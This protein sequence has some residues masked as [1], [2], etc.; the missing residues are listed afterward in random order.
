VLFI[1]V[2]FYI[3][4]IGSIIRKLYMRSWYLSQIFRVSV[5]IVT[6]CWPV[7]VHIKH[8]SAHIDTSVWLITA[9]DH[10]EPQQRQIV[11]SGTA[12][13]HFNCWT[14]TIPIQHVTPLAISRCNWVINN[15]DGL[16][17]KKIAVNRKQPEKAP[18][19]QLWSLAVISH[20]LSLGNRAMLHP[21]CL[22]V[23]AC[24]RQ[25]G[26]QTST[27]AYSIKHQRF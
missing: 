19:R 5:Y 20:N 3:N 4:V 2:T 22:S 27:S 7:G 26:I 1:V 10:N 11:A 21:G 13:D 6:M 15:H 9:M 17:R 16:Q 12:S 18:L 14:W 8:A 25:T 24:F 23:Q